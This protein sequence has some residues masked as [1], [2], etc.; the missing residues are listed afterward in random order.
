M[1]STQLHAAAA[2]VCAGGWLFVHGG[3]NNLLLEDLFVLDLRAREW[4]EVLILPAPAPS[5]RHS[6]VLTVAENRLFLFGGCDELGPA[7]RT[8]YC[9]QLGEDGRPPQRCLRCCVT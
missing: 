2:G 7:E 8:M 1:R 4:A 3:L 5:A 9:L 6:H